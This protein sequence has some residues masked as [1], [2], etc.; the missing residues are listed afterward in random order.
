MESMMEPDFGESLAITALSLARRFAAGTTMWCVAPEWPEHARHVAVEFVHPV[1]VGKR[2]LPAVS[3]DGAGSGRRAAHA[4]ARRRRRSGDQRSARRRRR[5]DRRAGAARGVHRPIW[6]GARPR[7]A[8]GCG[9][10]RLW[11]D[12]RR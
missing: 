9:R 8:R 2:A 7:P 1:L 10:P 4:G 6:I 12:R 3:V 5:V 11:A